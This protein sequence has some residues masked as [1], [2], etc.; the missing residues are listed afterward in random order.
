[1]RLAAAVV[2]LTIGG[3]AQMIRLLDRPQVAVP[4]HAVKEIGLILPGDLVGK[5]SP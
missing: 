5:W 3:K 1:M 4:P 2:H